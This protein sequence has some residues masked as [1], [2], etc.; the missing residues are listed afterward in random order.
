MEDTIKKVKV[1]QSLLKALY[2][3]K[4]GEE[5]G[6]KIYEQYVNGLET[7]AS[8]AMDLGNW[9]EYQCTGQIPRSGIVPVAKTLKGGGL[10]A[11][12]RRMEVQVEN[13]KRIIDR[14]EIQIDETGYVFNHD[15]YSGITDI[16]ATWDDERCIIDV[17]ST[18]KIDDKWSEFG[19]HE[20][21]FE[22]P[23]NPMAQYLTIQAVQYKL[24][25]RE[26]WGIP[27]IP[28]YFFV[29]STTDE[30][31]VKIY[32]VEVDDDRLDKHQ[33]Q[34]D[35]AYHYFNNVFVHKTK[36]ELAFPNLKRC[37]E[38]PLNQTCNQKIDVPLVK[39]IQVY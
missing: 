7:P 20:E 29:F 12:Y 23:D 19:W 21:K 17:K 39:T 1:S 18:G 33:E 31:S 15:K 34:L 6:I 3:F 11:E 28:F 22:N 5:C 14:Y 4:K 13:F 32:K 37:N 27:N 38:C 30:N 2:N 8:D 35:V 9:F 24:L 26:E 36:E 10:P 16:N 25:A